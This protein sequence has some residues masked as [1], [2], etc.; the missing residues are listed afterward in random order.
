MNIK[1]LTRSTL[2]IT[3]ALFSL[4]T[5]AINPA[6]AARI[7]YDFFIDVPD[8]SEPL[9]GRFSY[10]ESTEVN[11][12]EEFEPWARPWGLRTYESKQYEVDFIEF[13]F[14]DQVYTQADALSPISWTLNYGNDYLVG[15][16]LE[17]KTEDFR[18][19][20][21]RSRTKTW[22]YFQSQQPDLGPLQ[23]GLSRVKEEPI[24][25]PEP[26]ILGGLFIFSLAGL[27]VKTRRKAQ[28]V[29]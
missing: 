4:G 15:E 26:T 6:S 5:L 11:T 22:T 18:F 20:E 12:F 24:S 23:V 19:F 10:D 3:G 1:I 9:T 16:V 8:H 27:L 25:V 7:T 17:W 14:L 21:G 2:A 28:S 29:D 13:S